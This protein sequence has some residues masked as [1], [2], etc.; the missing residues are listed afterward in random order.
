MK[1]KKYDD[2]FKAEAVKLAL[3]S[4]VSYAEIARDL[5]VNY[6]IYLAH[7]KSMWLHRRLTDDD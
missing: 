6:G 1:Q 3:E 7:H 5:G 2:E 4:N